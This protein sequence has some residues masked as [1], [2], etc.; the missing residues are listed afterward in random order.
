VS[1]LRAWLEES[2]GIILVATILWDVFATILVPG[3]ANGGLSIALRVR[4]VGLP[5]GR[6]LSRRRRGPGQRPGNGFGPLILMLAFLSWLVMLILG[7]GLMLH[8]MG[9]HF[10]PRLTSLGQAFYLAGSSVVTLG[11][12][13]ID[14]HDGARWIILLA[15][16][17]GFG[18]ISAVISFVTQLQSALHQ[19]ETGVLTMCGMAGSPASGLTL[20]DSMA[21][22]DMRDGLPAFFLQWRDWSAAVLHSHV[23]YPVLVY[24]HS[25]DTESDWL[26]I[27]E[28][29]LDAATL[30]MAL[31]DE[32]SAGAATLMHRSGSRLAAHLCRLFT[33]RDEP[34]LTVDRQLFERAGEHLRRCGYRMKPLDDQAFARLAAL[35]QDY[36][37]RIR[38]LARHMG[39]EEAVLPA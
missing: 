32:E 20:L 2:F 30:V 7:F 27:L 25:V 35:R 13:E 16:I 14:A 18:V 33:L 26:Q 11:V 28:A 12:S 22:L 8:A 10:D 3:P 36:V 15:G 34:D 37:G 31:T 1:D 38:A 4:Q 19:R 21:A 9:N 39:A 24:F 23:S 5:I 17:S 29:L 6:Y